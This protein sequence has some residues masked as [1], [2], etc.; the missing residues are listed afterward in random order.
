[1][2]GGS[3]ESLDGM[4]PQG[5]VVNG[6][7]RDGRDEPGAS[8]GERLDLHGVGDDSVRTSDVLCFWTRVV[9]DFMRRSCAFIT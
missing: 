8:P 5:G 7:S 3:V 2:T 9:T 6:I 4:T 1:M